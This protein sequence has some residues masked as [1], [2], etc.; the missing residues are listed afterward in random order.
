MKVLKFILAVIVIMLLSITVLEASEPSS[1]PWEYGEMKD[2]LFVRT[3][4]EELSWISPE[5]PSYQKE[6]ELCILKRKLDELTPE[7]KELGYMLFENNVIYPEGDASGIEQKIIVDG[8]VAENDLLSSGQVTFQGIVDP[9]IN[10]TCF[11]EVKN[12]ATGK[13]YA[14]NLYKD[15][16]YSRTVTLPEGE[17]K[18]M[19]GGIYRDYKSRYVFEGEDFS[20]LDGSSAFVVLQIGYSEYEKA[21]S[22]KY[23]LSEESGA[24]IQSTEEVHVNSSNDHI[25]QII[26]SFVKSGVFILICMVGIKLVRRKKQYE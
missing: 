16:K 13:L 19:S 21:K 20:V 23:D 22:D 5:N 2:G 26:V 15:N 6:S 18:C 8:F 12:M 4:S 3:I 10:E 9:D 1:A 17:Y 11:V 14:I 7:M 24:S 25:K